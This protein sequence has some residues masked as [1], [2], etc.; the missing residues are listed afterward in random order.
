M[1]V[2]DAE[3]NRQQQSGNMAKIGQN[4]LCSRLKTMRLTDLIRGQPLQGGKCKNL[5]KQ[6]LLAV[7]PRHSSSRNYNYLSEMSMHT[8][9]PD[10]G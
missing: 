1:V 2:Q 6:A 9:W 8:K 3:E 4:S 10:H 7:E 5:E